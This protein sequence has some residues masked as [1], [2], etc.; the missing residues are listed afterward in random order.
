MPLPRDVTILGAECAHSPKPS[1]M[2]RDLSGLHLLVRAAL[3]A[4]RAHRA[5]PES[6]YER[7]TACMPVAHDANAAYSGSPGDAKATPPAESPGPNSTAAQANAPSLIHYVS[8][9]VL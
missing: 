6:A 2:Y 5:A 7:H 3:G 9:K 4:P 1:R 8:R